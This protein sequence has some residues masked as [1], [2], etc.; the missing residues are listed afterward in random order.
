MYSFELLSSEYAIFAGD[1]EAGSGDIF[2]PVMSVNLE[3]WVQV[4]YRCR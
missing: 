3:S 2:L 1:G 4:K